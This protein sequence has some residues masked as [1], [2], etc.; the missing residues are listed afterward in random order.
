MSC[1]DNIGSAWGQRAELRRWGGLGVCVCVHNQ[2]TNEQREHDTA[3]HLGVF[4]NTT[5]LE[6]NEQRSLCTLELLGAVGGATLRK[7]Y[8]LMG[9]SYNHTPVLSAGVPRPVRRFGGTTIEPGNVATT[10]GDMT[11]SW[12]AGSGLTSKYLYSLVDL[13]WTVQHATPLTWINKRKENEMKHIARYI[14]R[15]FQCKWLWYYKYLTI[16]NILLLSATMFRQ[17]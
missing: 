1:E 16:Y 3:W 11:P 12:V 5:T 9:C 4:S 8:V 14:T 17:I 13:F 10:L 15:L 6:M 2:W 7:N